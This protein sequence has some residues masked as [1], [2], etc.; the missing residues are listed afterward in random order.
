[1]EVSINEMHQKVSL[2][3]FEKD[4]ENLN[5]I[6][7]VVSKEIRTLD[8]WFDKFLDVCHSRMNK[9]PTT[10]PEWRLYNIKFDEYSRLKTLQNTVTKYVKDIKH[11]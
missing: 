10:S 7:K 1:M 4:I 5:K 3:V 8:K 2:C 9:N 6:E 11:I